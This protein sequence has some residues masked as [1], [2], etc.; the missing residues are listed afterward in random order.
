MN[1]CK[2]D[3]IVLGVYCG[4]IGGHYAIRRSIIAHR[5]SLLGKVKIK[6][7]EVEDLF[8]QKIS[9]MT[10][11]EAR[12]IRK[13]INDICN[14]VN[15][16]TDFNNGEGISLSIFVEATKNIASNKVYKQA[17]KMLDHIKDELEG[18]VINSK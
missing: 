9:E 8:K 1:K 2:K 16:E 3:L 14:C 6:S 13:R 17:I 10:E 11:D 7:M 12:T 4:T 5:N 15:Q 18:K